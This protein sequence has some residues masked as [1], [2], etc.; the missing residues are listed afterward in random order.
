[1]AWFIIEKI[2]SGS[3]SIRAYGYWRTW[4][5]RHQPIKDDA[6]KVTPVF[7]VRLTSA[8]EVNLCRSSPGDKACWIINEAL[9]IEPLITWY[10][11][12]LGKHIPGRKIFSCCIDRYRIRVTVSGLSCLVQHLFDLHR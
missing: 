9:K 1:M 7:H 2:V 3:R 6:H 8:R 5:G 11:R 4:R 12:F 10:G